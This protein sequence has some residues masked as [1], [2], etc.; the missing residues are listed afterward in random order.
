M[1]AFNWNNFIVR[2]HI[3]IVSLVFAFVPRLLFC[4]V[5]G[6]ASLAFCISLVT[7]L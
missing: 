2:S 1:P 3:A 7:S 6:W 5:G 4:L